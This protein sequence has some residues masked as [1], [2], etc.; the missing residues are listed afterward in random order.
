MR[1]KIINDPVFGFVSINSSFI[2]DLVHHP[3]VQRLSRI[4]QLGLTYYVY[5]GA[6]HTRFQH[7]LGAMHLMSEA[8]KVLRSKSYEISDKEFEAA[9]AAML[10]HDLGHG[11]FS[12]ALECTIVERGDHEYITKKLLEELSSEMGGALDLSI[13]MLRGVYARP[14]FHQLISGQL[15]MDRMDYLCRDSVFCGVV[16]GS[17]GYDRIIKMLSLV[18]DELVVEEKGIYSVE[19]FLIAR[20]LM[21]WQVY[22]HK[23]AVG[24]EEL[25]IR[26]LKRAKELALQGEDLFAS[27]SLQF[28]LQHEVKLAAMNEGSEALHHF[29][30]LDDADVMVSIKAWCS[31]AD[32]IISVLCK[33]LMYR[34]LPKFRLSSVEGDWTAYEQLR[35][36]YI[37]DYGLR[38]KDLDYF[39]YKKTLS[40]RIYTPSQGSIKILK[41][42]GTVSDI[43]SVSEIL[44]EELTQKTI[45]KKGYCFL[46]LS[47]AGI[48][49]F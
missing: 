2:L 42:D 40:E 29:V 31:H 39:I 43:T 30:L 15:D 9:L 17:V 25:L 45:C 12:H 7:A 4:K 8:L 44:N 6:Q 21:Y 13:Q 19:K 1:E 36:A 37:E 5:P 22:L 46:P 48:R 27:P 11:P 38:E 26:A 47:K 41:K 14:F 24:T 16:E 33:S 34:N 18:D 3:Y 20:R 28:F 10:L 23:T 32:P 35:K 49:A